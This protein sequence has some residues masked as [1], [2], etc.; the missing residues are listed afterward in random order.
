ME[1][2]KVTIADLDKTYCCVSEVLE[3]TSW[4]KSLPES[5]KWFEANLGKTVEGYHLL[6]GDKVVGHIYYAM[7][8]KGLVSYEIEPNVACV[9][10]TELLGPYLHKGYGKFMFDH[11]KSD[12]KKQ[13]VKGIMVTASDFK[14]WMHYELFL[15][16]GFKIIIEHAPFK[17]MYFPLNKQ[18]INVKVLSVN[19]T[20][21]KDK[22]EVTL[23]NNFFCP[24]GAYMYHLIKKVAQDFGD[25]VKIV[26]IEATRETI[27][28]YGTVEPLF[29]GK[30][31]LFGPAK[32]EDVKK[33][34]Q[35]EIDNFKHRT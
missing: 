3:S 9:Y 25:K 20:P 22:V 32:E 5:R 27:Q 26:E 8:E 17:T 13:G 12:L 33:A 4:A 23:F 29:N 11:M 30:T 15:K 28:K 2:K 34:I 18:S 35:E 7:S 6:D 19:Y 16:Q 14:E 31:K 24:V 21:S 10:C 1:I